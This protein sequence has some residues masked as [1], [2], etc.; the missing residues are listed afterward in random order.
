MKPN[1]ATN[2]KWK[3]P[4][5]N[6]VMINSDAAYFEATREGGWGCIA[7]DSKGDVLFAAAGKLAGLSQA[8]H[9]EALAMMKVISLA[10]GFGMGRVIFCTDYHP[11]KHAVLPSSL[12]RASLGILYVKL[13]ICCRWVS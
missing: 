4:P 8:I 13:S 9:A 11:L 10:E 1:V 12:D 2:P 6:W 3:P 7:R 5:S